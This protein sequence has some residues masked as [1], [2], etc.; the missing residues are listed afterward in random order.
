MAHDV[1]QQLVSYILEYQNSFYRLAYS[2]THNKEDS[3][4][5]VQN[6]VC[7][8]LEHHKAL[9]S[10]NAARTWFYRIL[11]NECLLFLKR[12]KR[13]ILTGTDD[14]FEIPYYEKNYEPG[15]CLYDNINHLDPD[16]QNI[17]KLRFYEEFSLKE[18]SDIT[19]MNLNT[20]KAKLYRGLKLLK[21]TIKE[22]DYE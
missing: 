4:D 15:S 21:L 16:T 13:E 6:A 2:Y 17:I 20:V 10:P 9:K 5:I 7:K 18:I 8:A 11:V 3:L 22:D 12:Q 19:H 14:P 1:Y